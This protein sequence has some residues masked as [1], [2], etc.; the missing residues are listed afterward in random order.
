MSTTAVAITI[1]LTLTSWI[2]PGKAIP[3]ELRDR[4]ASGSTNASFAEKL[5]QAA[6]PDVWATLLN[7]IPKN[8]AAALAEGNMLQ[9]VFF[10]IA[11]GIALSA[12]PEAK[13][14]PA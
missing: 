14:R 5:E 6:Q 1:G 4:L 7:I 8:P 3:Q 11:V 2:A 12:L 13:S 9:I 10:S